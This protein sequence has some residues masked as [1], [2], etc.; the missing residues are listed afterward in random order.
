MSRRS[1]RSA[2][3]E[4]T[5]TSAQ[6]A[7]VRSAPVALPDFSAAIGRRSSYLACSRRAGR[8]CPAFR[9]R[10]R[11][12]RRIWCTSAVG[13]AVPCRREAGRRR[14]RRQARRAAHAQRSPRFLRSYSLAL[15][16]CQV[17]PPPLDTKTLD[18]LFLDAPGASHLDEIAPAFVHEPQS[19]RRTG[20]RRLSRAQDHAI[21]VGLQDRRSGPVFELE[22]RHRRQS[23]RWRRTATLASRASSFLRKA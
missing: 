21:A 6:C 7:P 4:S 16:A 23:S 15:R 11:T 10:S 17:D 20:W 2:G 8:T 1:P 3:T 19:Q 18:A 13:T 9:A 12:A 22:L 14:A 5:K